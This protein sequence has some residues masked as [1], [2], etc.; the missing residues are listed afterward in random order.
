M[1]AGRETLHLMFM[2][3]LLQLALALRQNECNAERNMTSDLTDLKRR[4]EEQEAK[5]AT[6]LLYPHYR[7]AISVKLESTLASYPSTERLS[8]K[9]NRFNKL[10]MNN[11][12]K[13]INEEITHDLASV[14]ICLASTKSENTDYFMDT[15][16]LFI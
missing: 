11:G 10:T 1:K 3:L 6:V 16:Q 13:M 9:V 12:F 14:C 5:E 15:N 8:A 2:M 4:G 7:A